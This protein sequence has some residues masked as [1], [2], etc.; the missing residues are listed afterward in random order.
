MIYEFKPD[1][2]EHCVEYFSHPKTDVRKKHVKLDMVDWVYYIISVKNKKT[3]TVANN[4]KEAYVV[5]H[6]LNAILNYCLFGFKR[7]PS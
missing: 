4:T 6:T 1:I 7:S 2:V 5:P 3:S